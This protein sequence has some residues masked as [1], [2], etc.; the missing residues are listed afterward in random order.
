MSPDFTLRTATPADV[1]A[2]LVVHVAAIIANGPAAYSE[3]QVAAWAA[4]TEGTN[5]YVDAISDSA[6]EIVV[7]EA[8]SRV[9]GFGEL[10]VESGEV[11]A[12]FVDPGWDGRGI[13]SS[14]LSHFEHRLTDEGFDVVRLRAV[15]NA[16]GF[17]QQQCYERNERVTNTTTNGV[18]V[19]TVWMEKLL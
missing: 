4:K 6:T 12:I 11:E 5:R 9:V 3:K 19:D 14:I 8:D 10:A 15:L 1:E 7:A 18:E 13:G 2:I 16:V 17:Y